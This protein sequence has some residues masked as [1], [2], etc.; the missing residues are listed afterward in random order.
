ML[1]LTSHSQSSLAS[2]PLHRKYKDFVWVFSL[3][4][5]VMKDE[6]IVL[7]LSVRGTKGIRWKFCL[8]EVT[9]ERNTKL[10]L[11]K[12]VIF[13]METVENLVMDIYSQRAWGNYSWLSK[14]VQSEIQRRCWESG[15][16]DG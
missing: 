16:Y 13:R 11:L 4:E 15:C 10:R 1:G 14:C 5:S 12:E 8:L 7:L 3:F 2:Y 9:D 6:V